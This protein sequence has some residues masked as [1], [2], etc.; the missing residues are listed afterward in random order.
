MFIL[1]STLIVLLEGLIFIWPEGGSIGS[2][3]PDASQWG[4]NAG[5]GEGKSKQVSPV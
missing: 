3:R 1:F 5:K 2:F 4:T